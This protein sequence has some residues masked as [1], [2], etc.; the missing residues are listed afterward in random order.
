MEPGHFFAE[1]FERSQGIGAK[2]YFIEDYQCCAGLNG[3]I[4]QE[5]KFFDDSCRVHVLIET[6]AKG[7][8]VFEVEIGCI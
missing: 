6:C 4:V 5:T 3:L 2:L 1:V 7:F 8:V